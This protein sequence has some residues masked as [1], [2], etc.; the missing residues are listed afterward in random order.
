[1]NNLLKLSSIY[2]LSIF[3]LSACA[4]TPGNESNVS[5][6]VFL[7]KDRVTYS[8]DITHEKNELVFSLF[9]SNK[10][11]I[12]EINSLGGDVLDGIELGTWVHEHN[13]DIKVGDICA[14][15]CANYVFPAAKEKYLQENSILLWHGSSY[16]K[17]I[18]DLVKSGNEFAKKWREQEEFFFKKIGV[19]HQITTCGLTQVPNWLSLLYTLGFSD[20][21]GFDYSIDDI[22]RFGIKEVKLSGSEWFGTPKLD[23]QGTF[24]ATY[25][26]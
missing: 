21:K 26:D 12:I 18:D 3:L 6:G 9:K 16:Q 23:I 2:A 5:D 4:V 11:T 7:F 24:R 8:G 17:N 20:I 15:S 19:K 1:M 10:I 25:C 22:K 13:I 14:S